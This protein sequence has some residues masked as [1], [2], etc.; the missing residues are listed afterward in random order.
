MT[1]D[2]PDSVLERKA[3]AQRKA[4]GVGAVSVPRALARSLSI[5][6]DALW[7][8]GLSCD[9]VHHDSSA[10]DRA[11]RYVTPDQLLLVLE[12]ETG[13]RGLVAV[14]RSLLTGLIEIQTL[15]KVTQFPL[16]DRRFTPTDAAMVAP[17]LNAALPRCASMLSTQPDMAH[18]HGFAF[19]ALVDDLQAATLALEADAYQVLVY[20]INLEG[21]T[22]TGRAVFCFPEPVADAMDAKGGQQGKYRAVLQLVPTR[23]HAVLTRIHLPLSKARALRPGDVLEISPGAVTTASLVVDGG[24]VAAQ[25]KLGQLNG[26]RALR[27]G[28]EDPRA[29]RAAPSDPVLSGPDAPS[30]VDQ[31]SQTATDATVLDTLPSSMDGVADAMNPLAT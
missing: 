25:G 20:T 18:L 4:L 26:F 19:G 30:P 3:Q 1:D 29:P 2:A 13:A 17:L 16:D 27:I 6:A 22:R 31:G 23:M 9:L 12:T 24:F 15:G 11:L 8:L 5:A 28:S 14:D 7:G 10:A 21:E